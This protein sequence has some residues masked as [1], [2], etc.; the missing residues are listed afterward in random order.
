MADGVNR[1]RQATSCVSPLR[2]SRTRTA[3]SS[4]SPKGADDLVV[5]QRLDLLVFK[6]ALLHRFRCAKL[7]AA[8]HQHDLAAELG[9]V[10]L[11]TAVSPPPT[12]T[13]T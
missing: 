12:T 8:M 7:A 3:W 13:S 4:P 1:P 11:S 6:Q 5:P 9:E 10:W 2:T